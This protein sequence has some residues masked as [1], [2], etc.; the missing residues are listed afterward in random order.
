MG[1][2]RK[3]PNLRAPLLLFQSPEASVKK[4][5][6]AFEWVIRLILS[7][8]FIYAGWHKILHPPDFAQVI[9]NY[10]ILPRFV[11]NPLALLLPWIELASGICLI[12]GWQKRGA[13][14]IIGT[15]LIVFMVVLGAAWYRGINITCGCFSTSQQATSDLLMDLFR[16]G[17]LLLMAI[18]LWMRFKISSSRFKVNSSQLG[19]RA[20]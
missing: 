9:A 11:V 7:A 4:A 3:T 1:H 6:L 19:I 18:G 13:L 12:S 5:G 2:R 14:F 10:Q 20:A 17:M 8:A 16:D 15:L